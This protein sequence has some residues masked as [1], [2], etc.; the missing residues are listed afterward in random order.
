VC[1]LLE[2]ETGEPVTLPRQP[3]LTGAYGAALIALEMVAAPAGWPGRRW[4]R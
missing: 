3:E 2:A 4:A 1:A